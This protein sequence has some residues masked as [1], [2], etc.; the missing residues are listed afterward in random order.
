MGSRNTS[1]AKLAVPRL[2]NVLPRHRLFR[3]IEKARR[4][5]RVIWIWGPPGLGKTTL[6]ASYL[7][8]RKLRA[9][10]YQVDAGDGDPGTVFHYL[11]LGAAQTTSRRRGIL[12]PF[13]P[14]AL[15]GLAIFARRFFERLYSRMKPPAVLVF[16]NYQEAAGSPPFH[17]I[18]ESA[19]EELPS[20]LGIFVISRDPP[21][22]HLA[23]L[24]VL[25]T[26]VEL[27][28]DALRFTLP[29]TTAVLAL[30][31][32]PGHTPLTKTEVKAIHRRM[33]GWVAGL[34]LSLQMW[35]K[36]GRTLVSP[37]DPHETPQMIFEFLASEVF[38]KFPPDVQRFLL[39][40]AVLRRFTSIMA[41][42]LTG[43]G[44]G[45]DMIEQL[46][47]RRSFIERRVQDGEA[48]YQFHPLFREFLE[49]QARRE[50][51][52]ATWQQLVQRAAG[53]LE[54]QGELEEAWERYAEA[55]SLEDQIRLILEQAPVLVPQ[56]RIQTLERW[57]ARLPP[58]RLAANPWLVYWS[59]CCA[60]G[61]R[62]EETVRLFEEAFQGFRKAGDY[63]G[64]GL[65]WAGWVEAIVI[66]WTDGKPFDHLLQLYEDTFLKD[67]EFHDPQ[68]NSRVIF[69][70]F[71]AY[72]WRRP[73]SDRLPLLERQAWAVLDQER[74]PN[75]LANHC[76][77]LT[78]YYLWIGERRNFLDLIA[79]LQELIPED[80]MTS[81]CRGMLALMKGYV[82]WRAGNVEGMFHEIDIIE[83]SIRESGLSGGVLTQNRALKVFAHILQ[84][85]YA[86]AERVLRENDVFLTHAP[87]TVRGFHHHQVGWVAWLQSDALRAKR[88]VEL[89]LTSAAEHGDVFP[90]GYNHIG[91]AMVE[92]DLGR[93]DSAARHLADGLAIGRRTRSVLI[94]FIGYTAKAWQAFLQ[95]HDEEG[96]EALRLA[97]HIGREH[98]FVET[99]W[100]HPKRMAH[101]CVKALEAGIEVEYC[102]LLIR[103]RGLIPDH[104]PLHLSEWPWPIRIRTMGAFTIEVQGEPIV[105][106]RKTQKRT[107]ALLKALISGRGHE[108]FVENLLDKLWPE[109]EG[110]YAYNAFTTALHRLRKLLGS[111]KA[112]I[113]QE[114]KVFLHPQTVW[115]DAWAF[116]DQLAKAHAH[117]G[118]QHPQKEL[119]WT[120]RA[121]KLYKGKFLPADEAEPWTMPMRDQLRRHYVNALNKLTQHWVRIGEAEKALLAWDRAL[122][123]EPLEEGLYQ[124][125]MKCLVHLGRWNE[126]REVHLRC[127]RILRQNCARTPSPATEAILSERMP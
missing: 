78:G 77:I 8:V 36:P 68:V 29:E 104:P 119:E 35:H 47:R 105:F 108:E 20:D 56:G 17:T 88:E 30:V 52:P 55:G 72:F 45:K 60:F 42:A 16:D 4:C 117:A 61:V 66:Q 3:W 13:T 96:R 98:E 92:Q 37:S 64:M 39:A 34:V 73:E 21:P 53:L 59:A 93:L 106:A 57:L 100:F 112:V 120:E 86:S 101:L 50:L 91:V 25:Q 123:L 121:L 71:Q 69:A 46:Y 118:G 40:S 38:H 84:Q 82:H 24:R 122:E 27:E 81:Y 22:E 31:K 49:V 80:A 79:Y 62:V 76:Y 102:L 110:D 51:P 19:F 74:H 124:Q 67:Y 126:A 58:A 41:E 109:S 115:V 44:Q 5:H 10:W 107:M 18:L 127:Q 75:I 28:K 116:K 54:R 33:D 70:Q 23:R 83:R 48:I 7:R 43:M 95:G 111:E 65:A 85:D 87:S 99:G 14:E 6:V 2:S 63:D 97:L 94:Q 90:L 1:I 125:L 12:P 9:L 113:L 26:L 11:A 89:A 103:Q 15:P 32:R 114:G